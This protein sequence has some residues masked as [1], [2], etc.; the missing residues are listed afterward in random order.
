MP[1][2]YLVKEASVDQPSEEDAC[3]CHFTFV[4]ES[5]LST[6]S[7]LVLRY[8]W[9]LGDRTPSNFTL[10][11]DATGVVTGCSGFSNALKFYLTADVSFY[12]AKKHYLVIFYI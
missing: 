4:Q 10:I 2:D 6:D 5:T 3:R 12:F 7:Q 8:Q 1:S 9:F 11:P